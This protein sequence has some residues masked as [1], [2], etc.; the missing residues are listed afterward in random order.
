[1]SK[2]TFAFEN[3]ETALWAANTQLRAVNAS[4]EEVLSLIYVLRDNLR[5]NADMCIY[6]GALGCVDTVLEVLHEDTSASFVVADEPTR[7]DIALDGT[8][9]G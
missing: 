9:L 1:M 6:D 4:L 5:A 8:F 3:A 7:A 2:Q